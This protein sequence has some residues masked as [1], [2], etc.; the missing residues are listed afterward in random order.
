MEAMEVMEFMASVRLRLSLRPRLRPSPTPLDRLLMASPLPMPT[1]PGTLTMLDIPAS[2]PLATAMEAMED[3][4]DMDFMAN[5]RPRLRLSPTPSDRWLMAF[6]SP[7]PMPLATPT[8]L[9]TPASFPLAM[10]MEAMEA[11][12]AMVSME[13]VRLR[14]RLR[15]SPTPSDRLPTAMAMASSPE[16]TMAMAPSATVD[17]LAMEAMEVMESTASVRLRLMPTT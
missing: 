7:M 17:T 12:E 4:E 10:A 2:S 14:P 13:S 8:T 3:M 1:L 5:V 16:L 6:P 11:M 9:A 15:P